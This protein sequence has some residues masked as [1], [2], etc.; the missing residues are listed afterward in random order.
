ME[1]IL[2]G[3]TF[4]FIYA[5]FIFLTVIFLFIIKR[6]FDSSDKLPIPNIHN[7]VDPFE[8]SYLR[9]AETELARSVI[10]SLMQK[11]FLEFSADKTSI[12][13]KNAQM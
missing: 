8:I 12:N 9:G 11:D 1:T 4:L 10:F 13:R 5:V 6:F 3:P 2:Y 7:N